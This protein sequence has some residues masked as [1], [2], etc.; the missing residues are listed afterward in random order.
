MYI[1]RDPARYF[2]IITQRCMY[3]IILFALLRTLL[4]YACY[5]DSLLSNSPTNF[6]RAVGEYVLY[7]YT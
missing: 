1:F 7:I 6:K 4:H 3:N 2:I 5:L